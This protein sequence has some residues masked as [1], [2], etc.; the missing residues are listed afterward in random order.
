MVISAE[1]Q[2]Q[3]FII[4]KWDDTKW[5]QMVHIYVSFKSNMEEVEYLF[6][7]SL[8]FVNIYLKL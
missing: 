5:F 8:L 7:L 2:W 4:G 3:Q 1:Y 6:Y